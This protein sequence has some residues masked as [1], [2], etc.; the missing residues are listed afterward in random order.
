LASFTSFPSWPT[1]VTA[2][3]GVISFEHLAISRWRRRCLPVTCS[4]KLTTAWSELLFL[5]Q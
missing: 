2:A 1:L 5:L 3:C 4:T